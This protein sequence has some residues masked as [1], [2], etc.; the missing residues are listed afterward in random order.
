M[1]AVV[2]VW[3]YYFGWFEIPVCW[4]IRFEGLYL[5]IESSFWTMV[6]LTLPAL[7]LF[8]LIYF[9]SRIF[10]CYLPLLMVWLSFCCYYTRFCID[11]RLVGVAFY[12]PVFYIY[13]INWPW[14]LSWIWPW[15]FFVYWGAFA[16][17]LTSF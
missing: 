5:L 16:A 6:L 12:A 7:I 13:V 10:W 8:A 14:F 4:I 15:I 2:F 1:D 17:C 3:I 11:W 9:L